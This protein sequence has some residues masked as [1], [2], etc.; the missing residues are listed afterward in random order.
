[1]RD[2]CEPSLVLRSASISGVPEIGIFDQV[3]NSRLKR[4]EL[5]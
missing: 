2:P 1:M 3:G 5:L 4:S